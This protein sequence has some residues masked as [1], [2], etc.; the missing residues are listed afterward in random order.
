MS[1]R[2]GP[3][4]SVATWTFWIHETWR[5]WFPAFGDTYKWR[6]GRDIDDIH[7]ETMARTFGHDH[8]IWQPL[9]DTNAS[10]WRD[11]PPIVS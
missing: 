3:F 4:P 11:R 1:V 2:E 10:M 8:S 6:A 9:P 7:R 5:G